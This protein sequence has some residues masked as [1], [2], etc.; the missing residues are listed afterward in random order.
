[1]INHPLRPLRI[2]RQPRGHW[3]QRGKARQPV[4]HDAVLSFDTDYDF[5]RRALVHRRHRV[6]VHGLQIEY[7]RSR[8]RFKIPCGFLL[9]IQ[10]FEPACYEKMEHMHGR[11]HNLCNRPLS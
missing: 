2:E 8:L 9:G 4:R 10:R 5:P 11:G 1:M 7:S 3:Y 6:G